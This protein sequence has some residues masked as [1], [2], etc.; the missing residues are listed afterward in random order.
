ML[1][2]QCSPD[3]GYQDSCRGQYIHKGRRRR[4]HR[5]FGGGNE[6]EYSADWY[7]GRRHDF[8]RFARREGYIVV[9]L[10]YKK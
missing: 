10:D 5:L 4:K 6:Y 8:K 3:D 2:E 1:R 9:V 7:R